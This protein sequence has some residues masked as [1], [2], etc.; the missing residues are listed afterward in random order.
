MPKNFAGLLIESAE[1]LISGRSDKDQATCGRKWATIVLRP[2]WWN[3]SGRQLG[4]LAERNFP[5][6]FARIEIDRV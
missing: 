1:S 3:A 5:L 6:D 4:V 2:G